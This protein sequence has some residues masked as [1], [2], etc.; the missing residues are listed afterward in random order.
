LEL[1]LLR[2]TRRLAGGQ[3]LA[4]FA[5]FFRF[6]FL[7]EKFK[8]SKKLSNFQNF[9]KGLLFDFS[10]L[11]ILKV[12]NEAGRSKQKP[13]ALYSIVFPKQKRTFET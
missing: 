9:G 12:M 6:H 1:G 2:T 4:R 13:M 11:L 8:K 10:Y 3:S 7:R 5:A